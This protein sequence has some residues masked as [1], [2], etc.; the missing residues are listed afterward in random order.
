MFYEKLHHTDWKIGMVP[1]KYSIMLPVY[2]FAVAMA[3]AMALGMLAVGII[4]RSTIRR[5]TSALNALAESADE[6]AKGNLAETSY[7]LQQV[8]LP[9]KAMLLFYTDGLIEAKDREGHLFGENRMIELAS[10]WCGRGQLSPQAV[11]TAMS[12]AVSAFVGGAEQHD[13]LTMLAVLLR[14]HTV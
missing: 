1:T 8:T 11:I 10:R 7:T 6:V 5:S 9:P 3:L 14:H 4:C 12:E 2:A 13:D